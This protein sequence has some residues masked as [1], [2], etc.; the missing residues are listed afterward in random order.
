[1]L[2]EE[3]KNVSNKQSHT[4]SYKRGVCA[5]NASYTDVMY[6]SKVMKRFSGSYGCELTP[7]TVYIELKEV[8]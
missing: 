8:V 4:S 6:L 2:N 7:K 3:Y 1:M 5:V